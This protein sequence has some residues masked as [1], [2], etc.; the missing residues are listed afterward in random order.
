MT[1]IHYPLSTVDLVVLDLDGTLYDKRHLSL[2]MVL[3]ALCD[4]R[5]M[6][7]ER[8]TRAKMKGIYLGNKEA[9]YESYFLHLSQ[10][11]KT[12]ADSVQQWYENRY[13]PLMVNLIGKHHLAGDWIMPF[14]QQCRSRG[15]KLVVLS[16]YDHAEDKL[17]ALGLS[18]TLFDWVVSAPALGGLKPAPQLLHQV[19]QQMGLPVEKCLVIGDREDTDGAMARATGA[20]FQLIKY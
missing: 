16:D 19:A 9:F 11:L 17:Q 8:H 7:A 3:H 4:I 14:I 13:M 2:R 1:T 20:Q 5:K 12:S 15:I 18:P 6:Q 10:M